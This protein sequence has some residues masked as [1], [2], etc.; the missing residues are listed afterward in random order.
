VTFERK[1]DEASI[2]VVGDFNPRIFHPEWFLRYDLLRESEVNAAAES[3]NFV[4]A[5]QL[6]N[7]E[8]DWLIIQVRR[9]RFIAKTKDASKFRPLGDLVAAILQLLEHT[10]VGLLGLNRMMHYQVD[11][12]EQ[13]HVIGDTLAPKGIWEGIVDE[14]GMRGVE[15]EARPRTELAEHFHITIKP[16]GRVKPHGVYFNFNEQHNVSSLD[17]GLH[18]AEAPAAHF[19]NLIEEQWS[20]ARQHFASVTEKLL[21]RMLGE[22]E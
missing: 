19:S 22:D 12:E 2:V 20:E 21:E 13:W 17:E 18:E 1:L 7:F 9:D 14:P 3:D 4:L 15:L 5:E 10:P 6:A 8:T 16:S 11:S